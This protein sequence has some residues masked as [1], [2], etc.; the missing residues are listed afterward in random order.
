MDTKTIT[1]FLEELAPNSLAYKGEEMGFIYGD[2]KKDI[3]T[4]GVTWRP[5][6]Q[7]LSEAVK[8]KVDM[9]IIHE[10]LFQSK[11]SF[12]INASLL[13]YPPNEKREVLLKQGNILVYRFH[14]QWDDAQKG[15]N[16]TLAKLF[17]LENITKIPFGRVGDITPCSIS[18]LIDIVKEKLGCKDV[19][20]SGATNKNIKRIAV[21]AGSGNS[22]TEIIEIVKQKGADVLISGDVHDSK[23]RFATELGLTL[24]DAGGYFT[25]KPGTENLFSILQEKFS[26][27][28]VVFLDPKKPWE[29]R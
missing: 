6:V 9:M 11:K 27:L 25:E 26:K 29:I 8:K 1:N 5:T 19:L 20:L 16:E 14:S 22:L 12:I 24:I 21:V 13:K 17:S 28:E 10:P 23:A 4:I 18:V 15:N 3:S 7:V 2:P